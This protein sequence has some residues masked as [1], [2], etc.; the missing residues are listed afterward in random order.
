MVTGLWGSLTIAMRGWVS[1]FAVP[2]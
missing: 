1:G 2:L